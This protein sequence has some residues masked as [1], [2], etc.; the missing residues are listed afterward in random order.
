[1]IRAAQCRP[2][3]SGAARYRSELPSSAQFSSVQPSAA[4]APGRCPRVAAAP[5]PLLL[6]AAVAAAGAPPRAPLALL[7]LLPS[8]QLQ[9][10][11]AAR[12]P[13]AIP[14]ISCPARPRVK[15]MPPSGYKGPGEPQSHSNP[16]MPPL[17]VLLLALAL[18]CAWRLS[19]SQG[20]T[21]TGTGRPRSLPALPLVG[22]LLQ[23]AG[24][25]QLHLRLWRLQG[26]YGSLY[27]LWMG[28]HYVVVVNSYQHAR[29][30]LLKKG[31][32]FAGRPRTVSH[33]VTA[34]VLA[35]PWCG[36]RMLHGVIPWLCV[37]QVTTDLLSRGGKDI[38]FASYGPLWK[39]QRK[40]VH[41]ALSMFGE[42]SVA[43]EKISKCWIFTMLGFPGM[44]GENNWGLVKQL[45]AP[46]PLPPLSAAPRAHC[47]SPSTQSL[48]GGRIP[49]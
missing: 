13:P 48:P 31:K 29:E 20:P 10:W 43:L 14:P 40:L 28:S 36:V 8:P 30:V 6:T 11:P 15:G 3:L 18:L 37:P 24:H 35:D 12:H 41:A 25:P 4:Q 46:F 7:A 16:T 34:T 27:G 42:G 22:S 23:L 26:R 38:A 39:F 2:V 32:A 1:M 45:G 19:Y 49:V 44:P 17:A 47:P 21:G 33:G 9:C 5:K